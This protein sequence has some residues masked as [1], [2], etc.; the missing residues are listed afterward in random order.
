M[1]REWGIAMSDNGWMKAEIF[2]DD[3]QNILYPYLKAKNTHFPI[4]LFLDGH[5][6]HLTYQLSQL[7]S[8]LEIILICLY[9]NSTRI[10]QPADVSCFR[11]LNNLWKNGVLNWRR[12]NP[13]SKL[14]N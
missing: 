6:T 14:G 13:Y 2:V 4:I 10:F 3:I 12:N 8:K 7:C 11:P 5:K 1:W 9:P